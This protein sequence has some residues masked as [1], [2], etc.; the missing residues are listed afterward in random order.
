VEFGQ[1]II[2]DEKLLSLLAVAVDSPYLIGRG[3]LLEMMPG[4]EEARLPG[5]HSG[6]GGSG[7]GGRSGA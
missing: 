1:V 5:Y 6:S 4:E 3:D 2:G 7:P